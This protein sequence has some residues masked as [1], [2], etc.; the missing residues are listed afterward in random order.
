[1][2]LSSSKAASVGGLFSLHGS[3]CRPVRCVEQ[4]PLV[5][6]PTTDPV[7]ALTGA[8]P[9]SAKFLF[10]C[11]ICNVAL[12]H[13]CI[14]AVRCKPDLNKWRVVLRLCIRP[15]HG[16]FVLLAIMDIRAHPISF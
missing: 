14:P 1:M 16:A 2:E 3:I 7:L 6:T 11:L 5:A 10:G 12:W 8:H 15:L 9:P 4:S 13:I